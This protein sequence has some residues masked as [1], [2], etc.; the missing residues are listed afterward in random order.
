MTTVSR[1]NREALDHALNIFRDAMRP[2]IVRHLRRVPGTTVEEAIKRS[3]PHQKVVRFEQNLRDNA[4]DVAA[5]ID[6]ND[7]PH[8]VQRNWRDTFDT[9]FGNAN[10]VTPALWLIA[11]GRNQTAHPGSHDLEPEFVRTQL[12]HISDLLERI[13]APEQAGAITEIRNNLTAP[14][15]EAANTPAVTPAPTSQG[16]LIATPKR[17]SDSLK[18]WREVIPPTRDVAEGAFQQAEF[19][20]DLQQVFDGRAEATIYGHPFNFFSQ[21]YITPGLRILMV[22]ALRRLSGEGG[23]PV[24]QTKTGFGGG[25]THSLIALLHLVQNYDALLNSPTN[26]EHEHIASEIREISETAGVQPDRGATAAVAVLDG[27]YLATSDVEI[28]DNG[29]PLNTL[30]SVMAYQLGGQAA[31]D[32]I[33]N[34][35]RQGTAPGGAQLDQLFEHI[36]PCLILMDEL[37]AYARNATAEQRDR[38][39]T[40]MQALTQSAR[41][42]RTTALVVTLP[43]SSL[44]TGGPTGDEALARLENI[45]GRAEAIWEPLAVN[46]AFEV[47][48]RRL[49]GQVTDTAERNRTCEAFVNMYGNSRRE[50]PA[51]VG[52]QRYLER[53]KACYP[54]H[55]EVFDRLYS[56]WSSIPRFQR[57]RG[58][59]RMLSTCVSR[60]YRD[61]SPS[62]LIMPGDLPLGD[63]QLASE[64]DQLLPG[65]WA[66]VLS[67]IDSDN[68]RTD[69]IDGTSQRFQ[70]V[71]GAARRVARAVFLGSATSGATRGIDRRSVHLAAVR[72]TEGVPRYNEALERMVGDL[73]YLYHADDRYYF[74]AEENLN[75]VASDRK[76]TLDPALV[77]EKIIA[78]LKNAVGRRSDVIVCPLDTAAV[79]NA[80]VAR[81]IVLSPAQS[82]SNRASEP[83]D[84]GPAALE[85]LRH[86]G[87]AMRVNPNTLLFLATRKDEIRVLRDTTRTWMAW[88]SINSGDEDS[89]FQA[90]PN[91]TGERRRQVNGSLRA[92]ETARRNALVRAYRWAMAPYQPDPQQADAYTMN[93]WQT[94][95]AAQDNPGDIVN[96]ALDTLR[97]EEALLDEVTP[98]ALEGMLQRYFWDNR[99]DHIAVKDLW[100]ALTR[101]VYL[102]RLPNRT[103]LEQSIIAGVAEGKFGYVDGHDSGE[104]LGRLRFRE[105]MDNATLPLPGLVVNPVMAELEQEKRIQAVPVQEPTEDATTT[106][107]GYTP[108]PQP[109]DEDDDGTSQPA[110]YTTRPRRVVARKTVEYDVAMYDFNQLRDEIIRNLRND[111]GNVT[112]EVIISAEKTDGFSESIT[113]AV[114]ENSIQME[115]DFSESDHAPE[116]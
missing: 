27:A 78:E 33:G 110:T 46:E 53:M 113:R 7:F 79:S 54:I 42:S 30:W 40:F 3:L 50:Y 15:T 20:A 37:V 104:Y 35:A 75:K 59:L 99:H 51:H 12:F 43:E 74:H 100:D 91:L 23:D 69:L 73:Y 9:A 116:P 84:A 89:G 63:P 85:L 96:S 72:P 36:G 52:E 29:D 76:D 25:K 55:P 45:L 92:A 81:L 60:L 14:A 18:P 114:R 68:G 101:N 16:E 61:Q 64:F 105:P 82:L 95:T 112:V 90:I 48:R 107:G 19:M 17:T 80:D 109:D 32:I 71:G 57:T 88:Q 38:I 67:E 28:T 21:T 56:D 8:L 6:V 106:N 26:S 2:F 58:V 93:S 44:E 115:L 70:E 94:G 65:H 77:D 22:N 66:P 24:I 111:G 34:A 83:D 13:S 62:P 39:Y 49:F 1:P 11:D 10:T 98:G 86:R 102:F 4:G 41:R 103:V 31:Y 97:K 108:E 87:D 47:V 5:C